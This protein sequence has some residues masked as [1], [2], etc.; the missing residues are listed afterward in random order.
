MDQL[1]AWLICLKCPWQNRVTDH[2]FIMELAAGT[3]PNTGQWTNTEYTVRTN[4][5]AAALINVLLSTLPTS[6]GL[7]V[8]RDSRQT[9]TARFT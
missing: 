5:N 8:H 7:T 6:V 1:G 4:F 2:L 3:M 9:L